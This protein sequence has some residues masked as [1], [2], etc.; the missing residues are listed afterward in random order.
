MA[1]ASDFKI[2]SVQATI[3][4]PDL[5]FTPVKVL[6]EML[7]K[8][9]ECF[10]GA[11]LSV[12]GPADMP[13]E[14]PRIILESS[15]K[16]LKLELASA[17]V[18]LFRFRQSNEDNI[19]IEEF[20]SFCSRLLCEYVEFVHAKTGRLASVL[21]RFARNDNPGIALAKHFCKER[22]LA[23]PLNRPENFE[24]HAHKR[25]MMAKYNVN[26]WVRCKTGTAPDKERIILVEQDFNTLAEE[27]QER[28]YSNQEIEE[29]FRT[30]PQEF[31]K[32]LWL[33]FPEEEAT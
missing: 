14:I 23:A 19:D 17:R 4:T 16:H 13:G 32:V 22:W 33:Y 1:K 28:E 6:A 15:K 27:T 29:F 31:D 10:D 3:F 5:R 26:S 11:P 12:P 21:Q 18:N 25:F 8:W 20:L 24:I 9:G 2:S 30:V 7:S